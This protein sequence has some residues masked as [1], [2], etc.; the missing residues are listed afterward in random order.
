MPPTAVPPRRAKTAF[1]SNVP[2]ITVYPR[3]ETWSY[4]VYL[5]AHPLTLKRDRINKSGFPSGPEAGLRQGS[6]MTVVSG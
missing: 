6:D 2:G 4:T 1:K 3:G 5:D